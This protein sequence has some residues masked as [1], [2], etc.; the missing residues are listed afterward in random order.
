MVIES[1]IF[2]TYGK[3]YSKIWSVFC[4][5]LTIYGHI[6][7]YTYN[8]I[9]V[10]V[11]RGYSLNIFLDIFL[12]KDTNY[13]LLLIY[14]CPVMYQWINLQRACCLRKWMLKHL[15]ISTFIVISLLVLF[16]LSY[17]FT[18]SLSVT[19]AAPKVLSH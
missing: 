19:L 3:G 15:K 13:K 16:I 18:I 17:F 8:L 5:L 1:Y 7:I 14:Y 6:Y 4:W 12:W 10:R 11:S 2:T 9:S